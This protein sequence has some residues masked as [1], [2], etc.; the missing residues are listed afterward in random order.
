M[1][2]IAFREACHLKSNLK[3]LSPFLLLFALV[4]VYSLQRTV[5]VLV[6]KDFLGDEI[7]EFFAWLWEVIEKE[8]LASLFLALF[9]LVALAYKSRILTF[10]RRF[11]EISHYRN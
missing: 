4:I 7:P 10:P 3:I 8:S 5:S 6:E 9:G 2:D 11:R 1:S